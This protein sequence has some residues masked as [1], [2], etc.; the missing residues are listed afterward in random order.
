[1]DL[2]S[3]KIICKAKSLTT[4]EDLSIG[5]RGSIAGF[6]AD[7]LKQVGVVSMSSTLA[8]NS[9]VE[10][11]GCRVGLVCIGSEYNNSVRADFDTVIGGGHDLHGEELNPL[12]EDAAR[13]F[14]ESLKGKVDGVAITGYLAVRNP[15]HEKRVKEI[16]KEILDVPIVCGH[17]LSSGLGFNERTATCVMNAKL[18]PV[19]DDLI[20]SVKAV[21]SEK[22]IHAPLMIVK[23]DGSMMGEAVAKER[24]VETI[25]C[26]PAASLIGA[27][28]LTGQKDAIVMDMGGTTTDIGILR[29]ADQGH[30]RGDRHVRYRWG[31]S[32]P[33][34]RQEDHP[35]VSEGR[36]A[37]HRRLALGLCEGAHDQAGR[38]RDASDT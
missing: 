5:I 32:Y 31:Q 3:G 23:G 29:E 8:T 25:L 4:R 38:R 30:G 18:I 6:D 28:Y 20:R 37:V 1:M 14:L 7:L 10:G 2:D 13:R 27:M 17:E 24:P 36:A 21:L 9:V 26:G 11:K 22:G 34:Q 19:I 33:G 15:S 12:D 35:V 16:A